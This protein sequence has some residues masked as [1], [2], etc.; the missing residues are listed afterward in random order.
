MVKDIVLNALLMAVWW[1]NSQ[2]QV[3]VH[4]GQGSQYTSHELQ[5]FLKYNGLE[6]SMSH[7]NNYHDNAVTENFFQLFT[8]V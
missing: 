8:E 7:C 3:L 1:R 6:G 5:L 4:S 2:R